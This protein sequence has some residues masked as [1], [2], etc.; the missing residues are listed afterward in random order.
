MTRI[1]T[2]AV[3]S[4]A[5]LFALPAP[6][7]AAPITE[8]SPAWDCRTDGNH[9]CGPHNAQGVAPGLYRGFDLISPWPTVTQCVLPPGAMFD[10]CDA[11]YV[12]PRFVQLTTGV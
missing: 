2:A 6:A 10:R 11:Y 5:A 12:D 9:I 3:L 4:I 1:I 7:D 8:D